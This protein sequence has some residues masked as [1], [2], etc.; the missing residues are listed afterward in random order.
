MY[1]KLKRGS[2]EV[3]SLIIGIVVIGALVV[4]IAGGFANNSKNTFEK[5]TTGQNLEAQQ[6]YEEAIT[7]PDVGEGLNLDVEGLELGEPHVE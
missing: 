7:A 3:V 4:A 6:Y 2:A 5:G 1:K